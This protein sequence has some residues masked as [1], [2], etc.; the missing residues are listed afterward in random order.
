[1]KRVSRLARLLSI[2][3]LAGVGAVRF[4]AG[5]CA[6][7]APDNWRVG[8]GVGKGMGGIVGCSLGAATWWSDGT[9]LGLLDIDPTSS[10]AF[11]L[12]Y[13]PG[14]VG[15]PIPAGFY[16]A[17]AMAP[18]PPGGSK[19]YESIYMWAQNYTRPSGDV[20]FLVVPHGPGTMPYGYTGTLVL[21]YVPASAN[22]SGP[23]EFPLI[24]DQW[25]EF[26]LPIVTVTD[27]LQGVRMHVT[28]NAPIPE[29]S[30]LLALCTGLV[31]AG[32]LLGKRKRR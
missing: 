12:P 6:A 28:V 31:S 27:P 15:A 2:V 20:T 29:P 21:D 8:V 1:M 30:S 18:I 7:D 13:H 5:Q 22:W 16:G 14:S 25:N 32:A 19:T 23:M 17:L 9:F 11:V 24:L 26:T 3:L 10:G 4:G